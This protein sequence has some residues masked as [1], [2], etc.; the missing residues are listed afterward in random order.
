MIQQTSLD[1]WR[2]IQADLGRR[3]AQVLNVFLNY[4]GFNYTNTELSKVLGLP[5]NQVTPRVYE[6]RQKGLLVEAT[7]RV[8]NVTG[9]VVIA[10]GL[11]R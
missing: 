9:R 8:C 11:N 3:Q 4:P 7:R 1:A 5:I 2:D 10:W 6:L